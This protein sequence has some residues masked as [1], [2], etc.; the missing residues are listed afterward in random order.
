MVVSQNSV[1][2]TSEIVHHLANLLNTPF[3]SSW[4][5]TKLPDNK[6]TSNLIG[7]IIY[8]FYEGDTLYQVPKSQ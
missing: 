8:F 1:E 5:P 4:L 3:I 7:H 6:R 2:E